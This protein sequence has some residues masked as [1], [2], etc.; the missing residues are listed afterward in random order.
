MGVA[1]PRDVEKALTEVPKD[2]VVPTATVAAA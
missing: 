1:M 2:F